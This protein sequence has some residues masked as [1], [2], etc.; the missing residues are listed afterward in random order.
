MINATASN[1]HT[2]LEH[3][4]AGHYDGLLHVRNQ[5]HTVWEN[6]FIS[7]AGANETFTTQVK[8]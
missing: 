2:D 7:L 5:K 8:S 4:C 1:C 6:A 3:R